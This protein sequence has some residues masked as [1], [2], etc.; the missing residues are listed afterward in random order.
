MT[1]NN[2]GDEAAADIDDGVANFFREC[3]AAGPNYCALANGS[4]AE[5]LQAEFNNYLASIYTPSDNYQNWYDLRTEF[6][7]VLKVPSNFPGFSQTLAGYYGNNGTNSTT[8]VK[9]QNAN[10]DPTQAQAA[11]N[12]QS[13]ALYG[14]TC[15]DFEG[16]RV[17]DEATFKRYRDIYKARSSYAGDGGLLWIL[18][19]C[20]AWQ[21][22]AKEQFSAQLTGVQTRKPV[23]FVN[24]IYDPVTPL[25]SAQNSSA[26]FVGSGVLV[27]N[28][29]GVSI[30]LHAVTCD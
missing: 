11:A 3:V 19:T 13:L 14:V 24:T 1:N 16:P 5:E 6:E 29:A 9:R 26:G 17:V 27:S 21:T 25:V 10:F 30:H 28:G 18:Y 2:S 7:N 23:L 8:R 4:T 22:K 20:S 12:Q 15:N